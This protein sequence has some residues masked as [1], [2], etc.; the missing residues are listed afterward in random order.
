MKGVSRVLTEIIILVI[1]VILA[2][3]LFSPIANYIALS[4]QKLPSITEEFRILQVGKEDGKLILYIQ[5]LGENKK[6]QKDDFM[7]FMNG[8]KCSI[9]SVDKTQWK[10]YDVITVKVRCSEECGAIAVYLKGIYTPSY[11]IVM[12]G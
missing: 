5:N 12:R 11:Y 7:A 8:E 1:A 2:L 6:V 4:L 3:M 9:I 10:K